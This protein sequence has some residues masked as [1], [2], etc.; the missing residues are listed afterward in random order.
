MA[1]ICPDS[2]SIRRLPLLIWVALAPIQDSVLDPHP[3]AERSLYPDFSSLPSDAGSTW[4]TPTFIIH[5]LHYCPHFLTFT[6]WPPL[7]YSRA[8]GIMWAL[9]SKRGWLKTHSPVSPVPKVILF[10]FS[11]SKCRELKRNRTAD[12]SVAVKWICVKIARRMWPHLSQ[13]SMLS[14]YRHTAIAKWGYPIN[15]KSPQGS[16]HPRTPPHAKP[17]FLPPSAWA[18]SLCVGLSLIARDMTQCGLWESF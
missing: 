7:F 14:S 3:K 12:W 2:S 9:N 11:F 13:V 17:I 1:L 4:H 16:H 8:V 10:N 15:S 5:L 6:P 18:C